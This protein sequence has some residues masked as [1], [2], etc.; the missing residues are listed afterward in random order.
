MPTN[1]LPATM[2]N[3]VGS[4]EQAVTAVA[5]TS[6]DTAFLKL[7]KEGLWVFGAD[8][9]EVEKG[10]TWAV[11]PES[12][13]MGFQCWGLEGSP[14]EGELLGEE[15]ALVSEPPILK[16]NL[17]VHD[18]PWKQMLSFQL[19]C[20]DGDHK[21]TVLQFGTTSKGG[22]KAI[23]GLMQ[24]LVKRIK[25]PDADGKFVPVI[26]LISEFYK[27][28]KYGRI[29]T[30]ILQ[31]NEWL[32]FGDG[33]PEAEPEDEPE[34]E[35]SKPRRKAKKKVVVEEVEEEDDIEDGEIVEEEEVEEEEEEPATRRRRRRS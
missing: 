16:A 20:L 25:A 9:D 12:F 17:V 15:M 7:L 22:L 14:E 4:L 8:E 33:M 31:V 24:K 10:S 23:N 32:D 13:A 21:G 34:E 11:N 30:P 3:L 35:A 28:K 19:A 2:T 29:Y 1:N 18:A 5:V 6:G 26:E 27:H